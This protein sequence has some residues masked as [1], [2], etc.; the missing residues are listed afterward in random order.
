M[1]RVAVDIGGTFTDCFVAWGGRFLQSKALT[2]H[3]NLALGFNEAIDGACLDL[4]I[5]RTQLLS[6]VDSVRY[7]TTLGTN[8]LIE[9]KGPKIG[10]ICTQ[11]FESDVPISRGRGFAEGLP[12]EQVRS[13]A[14]AQRPDALV[15]IQHIRA[16]RER[17]DYR[18]KVLID[19]DEDHA[20]RMLREIVDQGVQAIVVN[21][22]NS[23]ENPEHELRMLEL[24][25]ED[26][27]PEMLGA[28]PMILA[29][30]VAGRKGE[31]VRASSAIIDAYLHST[32]Y[33]AMSSLEQN[34]RESGYVKPMLLVHN[35]G[36]MAQLNSTDALH[37]VHSGPVAG[38][39]CRRTAVDAGR[40]GQYRLR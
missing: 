12:I 19:L 9:R 7:A 21:L 5:S 38:V 17:V 22:T 20:R 15:P 34:L 1:K 6:E 2:T 28:I 39:P 35:T 32:M 24:F 33:F 16:V 18:G 14:D 40:S 37:T 8:A 25:E 23:V 36:G 27:P 29:H 10:L 13:L 4:G 30:Q 11:G 3:Q 26:Y 31:Y